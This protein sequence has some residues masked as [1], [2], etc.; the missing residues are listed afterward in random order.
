MADGGSRALSAS[1]LVRTVISLPETPVACRAAGRA[2]GCAP[3]PGLLGDKP[4]GLR[5]WLEF[6]LIDSSLPSGA[7]SSPE[8]KTIMRGQPAVTPASG[9][10]GEITGGLFFWGFVMLLRDGGAG[11]DTGA[12]VWAPLCRSL[13]LFDSCHLNKL[14][15]SV[16]MVSL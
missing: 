2:E 15:L 8:T 4:S 6:S 12:A 13:V 9:S 11:R 10:G 16:K 3:N 14:S 1:A 7:N 5:H